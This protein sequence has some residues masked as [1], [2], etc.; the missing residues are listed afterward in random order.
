VYSSEQTAPVQEIHLLVD[1]ANKTPNKLFT[2]TFC[3]VLFICVFVHF[4]ERIHS[5]LIKI[6]LLDKLQNASVC[7]CRRTRR[8]FSRFQSLYIVASVVCQIS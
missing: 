4:D 3:D 1:E 5:I 7:I 6:S 8:D 2:K